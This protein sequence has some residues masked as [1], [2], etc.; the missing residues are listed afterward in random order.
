MIV[1]GAIAITG[2]MNI[3]EESSNK[4]SGG[5]EVEDVQLP[6]RDTDIQIEGP[7]V[8]EYQKLFLETWSK[9]NGPALSDSSYFPAP[10]ERGNALVQVVGSRAGK[11][12]RITFVMYVSAITFAEHS[13]HLTNA[14]F[15]PDDQTLDA[16][17]AAAKRGVDV[18]VIV[19]STTD[20]ELALS[21]QRYNYSELLQSGVKLYEHR[22]SLLHAKTAVIDGVWS[23]IG[24]A[25]LDFWSAASN[26]ESNAIIL[27]GQF[28]AQ[29]ERVFARDLAEV[30]GD[31]VGGVEAPFAVLKAWRVVGAFVLS[32]AVS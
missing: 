16:L 20:S 12:N 23:T 29:M 30:N 24:S 17:T 10:K 6:W 15:V 18:K 21:A 8:A 32:L 19:P 3:S 2:G 26:D 28:A 13:I 31:S 1:D 7:A 5:Q 25:N 14:Y 4:F 9:H 11:D 27:S 22:D